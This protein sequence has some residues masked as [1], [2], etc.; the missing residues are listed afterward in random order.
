[1]DWILNKIKNLCQKEAQQTWIYNFKLF[2]KK[3]RM[4]ALPGE[5]VDLFAVT[6]SPAVEKTLSL[7]TEV[8]GTTR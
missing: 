2:F 1:M 8:P 4:S 7:G 6:M 3:M 5:S